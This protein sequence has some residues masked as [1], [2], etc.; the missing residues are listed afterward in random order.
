[1]HSCVI[2]GPWSMQ[3]ALVCTPIRWLRSSAVDH[4]VMVDVV[5]IGHLPQ[6]AANARNDAVA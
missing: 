5:Q 1:M 6:W 3:G 2:V 4:P